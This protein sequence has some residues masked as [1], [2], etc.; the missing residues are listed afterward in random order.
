VAIFEKL[1]SRQADSYL[2]LPD[3]DAAK[4]GLEQGQVDRTLG[5]SPL[6]GECRWA[7]ALQRTLIGFLQLC[8]I[9]IALGGSPI[10]AE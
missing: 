8:P 1:G 6:V 9:A 4:F 2:Q 10:L 5:N 3:V 7:M